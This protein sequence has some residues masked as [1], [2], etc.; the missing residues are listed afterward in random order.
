VKHLDHIGN[1]QFL[2]TRSVS[3]QRPQLP[4]NDLVALDGVGLSEKEL[5][6]FDEGFGNLH[7]QV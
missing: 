3:P 7:W 4:P 2:P 5:H 6:V 1:A